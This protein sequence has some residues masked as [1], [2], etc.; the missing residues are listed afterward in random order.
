M[1]GG[2]IWWV[3]LGSAVVVSALANL[4]LARRRERDDRR[5]LHALTKTGTQSPA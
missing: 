3:A 5:M 2:W 4:L 1:D